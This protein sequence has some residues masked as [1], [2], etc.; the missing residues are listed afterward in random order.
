[1]FYAQAMDRF[2]LAVVAALLG[3]GS[4]LEL[5]GSAG[6]AVR[7]NTDWRLRVLSGAMRARDG[8]LSVSARTRRASPAAWAEHL[9]LFA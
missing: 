3:P 7:S 8:L 1:M 2:F 5:L 9:M 6:S 4:S